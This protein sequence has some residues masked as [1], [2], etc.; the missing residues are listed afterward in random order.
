MPVEVSPQR[1][2]GTVATAKRRQNNVAGLPALLAASA[3]VG[4]YG[5]FNRDG[6]YTSDSNPEFAA[7]LKARDPRSGLRDEAAVQAL[8]AAAGL[9]PVDAVA[10]PANNRMLVW[11]S[12]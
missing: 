2:A 3:V 9:V 7:S 11:R 5:P 12:A 4:V 8:A 1:V 6:G 10:M